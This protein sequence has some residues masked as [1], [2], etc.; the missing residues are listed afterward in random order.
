MSSTV[1]SYLKHF[2]NGP[3]SFAKGMWVTLKNLGR[4][5]VTLCYP[6]ERPDLKPRFRGLHGLTKNPETGDLNCIG[7]LS[8]ARICPDD[9]I[10]ISVERREGHPGRY[11]VDFAINIGPC[12]FC[13]LCS[14]VCPAPMKALIMSSEFEIAPFSRDGENLVLT[15]EKLIAI[16]EREVE[17]RQARKGQPE[18]RDN[19][20]FT[21]ADESAKAERRARGSTQATSEKPGPQKTPPRR[22][23][24][25]VESRS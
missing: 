7:C 9:L 16:G 15:K 17:R 10:S 13:G 18:E 25:D 12:C 1:A 11:P 19:P 6:E 8:C 24:N 21:W 3:V 23:E 20:Y 5:K 14:E 4:R 22:Q 2:C